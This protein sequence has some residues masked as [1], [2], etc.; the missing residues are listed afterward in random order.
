[1]LQ[2]VKTY[3][4]KPTLFEKGETQFWDEPHIAQSMLK[5]HL[6]PQME[7]ATRKLDFV[8]KSVNWIRNMLP[9]A[10][11]KKLLDLGC[12]PGIYAELFHTVGY[13]VTGGI[14]LKTPF[15][16][17]RKL[18][19]KTNQK[20]PIIILITFNLLLKRTMMSLQ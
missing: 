6:N 4:K 17:Q 2:T 18:Q 7:A 11:Y 12:G 5:A 10:D 9:P 14:F 13:E 15:N 1:M 20:L 8:K 19:R 16:M 3:L